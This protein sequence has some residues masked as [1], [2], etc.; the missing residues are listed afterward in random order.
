MDCPEVWARIA[1][2][3]GQSQAAEL[4]YLEQNQVE[5]AIQM[6][7]SL[8]KWENGKTK[9]FNFEIVITCILLHIILA[10]HLAE[11][12]NRTDVDD[13]KSQYHCWL[14]D[15]CQEEKAAEIKEMEGDKRSALQLYMKAGL[16]SKAAK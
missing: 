10:I 2:L 11:S 7:L 3:N 9:K 6:Y 4:L 8:H 14:L 13:L 1:V 15:T 5:K 12:K 16:F